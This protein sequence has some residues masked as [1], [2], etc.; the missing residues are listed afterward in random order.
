MGIDSVRAA[1]VAREGHI[2]VHTWSGVV[3]H[4]YLVDE[5]IKARTV[6]HILQDNTRVG[7]GTLFIV[8]VGIIPADGANVAPDEG[9]LA[10][11]ALFK[12]K[13]Y[14]Y[15]IHDGT[16]RIGQVHFKAFS[17][18]DER[19]IWY[20]PDV[21]VEHLPS[22]RVWVSAP[23]TIKGNWLVANFGSDAFWKQADYSTGRDSFRREQRRQ[24][25]Q[26]NFRFWSNPAWNGSGASGF[27]TPASPPETQLD[28]S[29][30]QLGL[31][32]AASGDEVKAAFR[33]LARE[34]H[35]DVSPLPKDE[36]EAQ[37]KKIY[38]AYTYI[39]TANGW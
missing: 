22:Y 14:T 21:P 1:R 9:L 13:L 2:V 31:T 11:H 6:K 18:S 23:Q 25:A 4:V 15:R 37:F 30:R 38:D 35:P 24:D 16:P 32:P 39:K 27:T 33:R 7:V 5:P 34:V 20:G 26:T 29:Y 12:N 3:I 17:R 10:L 8:N 36:A 19:E 28:R